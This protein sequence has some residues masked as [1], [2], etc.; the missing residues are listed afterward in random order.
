MIKIMSTKSVPAAPS[1]HRP[2]LHNG[3]HSERYFWAFNCHSAPSDMLVPVPLQFVL[4]PPPWLC[5]LSGSFYYFFFFFLCPAKMFQCFS[6]LKTHY[7]HH[8]VHC[9]STHVHL[10]SVYGAFMWCW[11][12][13]KNVFLT[14]ENNPSNWS[15]NLESLRKYWY[16]SW[17]DIIWR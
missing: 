10:L 15:N 3:R 16:M 2:T 17:V 8:P 5:L 12:N 9:C 14:G 1:L 6:D 4:K 7:F 13:W 11:T